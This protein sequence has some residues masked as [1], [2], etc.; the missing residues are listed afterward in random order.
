MFGLDVQ[1]LT[2]AASLDEAIS[3]FCR[4]YLERREQETQAAGADQRKRIKL[5][6]EFTPRLS[7]T[8]VGLEGSL[9]RDVTMTVRYAFGSEPV[10][11]SSLTLTPHNGN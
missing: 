5:H 3:E 2:E 6:D 7:M 8:L 10:Y 11:E 1:K 4:F 9:S